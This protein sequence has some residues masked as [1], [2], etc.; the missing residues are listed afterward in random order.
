MPNLI[1]D[2]KALDDEAASISLGKYLSEVA[3]AVSML[4]ENNTTPFSPP[5]RGAILEVAFFERDLNAVSQGAVE[6]F[7][8]CTVGTSR[9]APQKAHPRQLNLQDSDRTA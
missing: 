1:L 5:V 2:L 6:S 4:L 8:K 7:T 3:V 9:A